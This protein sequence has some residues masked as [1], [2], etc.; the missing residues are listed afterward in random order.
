MK[1]TIPWIVAVWMLA[2]AAVTSALTG[3][4]VYTDGDVVVR[5]AGADGPGSSGMSLGE[6]D[7]VRTGADSLAI[8]SVGAEAEIKLRSNT[9]L[10]LDSLGER[11]AVSLASGSA[12]SRI[13]RH[14]IKDYTLK[15][16]T[17][18]A[19]V[20]GTEFF[21]AYGRT[22]DAQ[23]DIWLCVNEGKVEVGLEGSA[24][25]VLVEKGKGINIV[26]GTKLTSP[27]R[28]PWTRKLN[29]NNDVG[30]GAVR[31]RT[32]LDQAYSDLLDQDYD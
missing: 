8:I 21:V 9:T 31:D 26:A 14:T 19:G 7:V 2:A 32:S 29:W 6:G 13:T 11:V 5:H 20:R 4:L 22:I 28:Y 10:S 30:A 23:P 16:T 27:R 12:F 15:A 1:A 18:V 24:D 3:T 17:A 25:T